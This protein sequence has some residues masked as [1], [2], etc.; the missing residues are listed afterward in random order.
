MFRQALGS[1]ND[2]PVGLPV[3]LVHSILARDKEYL[4]CYIQR[5]RDR[6][7]EREREKEK[8]RERDRERE[9]QRERERE[10]ESEFFA[11]PSLSSYMYLPPRLKLI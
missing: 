8:E 7:R 3:G 4:F 10:R 2:F 9:R 11:A 1:P 5:K 6:E